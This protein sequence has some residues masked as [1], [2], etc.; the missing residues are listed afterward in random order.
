MAKTKSRLPE[1]RTM[2]LYKNG[3][4]TK[5]QSRNRTIIIIVA[6]VFFLVAVLGRYGLLAYKAMKLKN[7]EAQLASY[8][9]QLTNYKEVKT[10][11][12]R[13]AKTFM[14]AEEKALED[15]TT[16]IICANNC[17]HDYGKI[18]TLSITG[19]AATATVLINNMH[20]VPSIVGKFESFNDIAFVD[21]GTISR[22]TSEGEEGGKS[23]NITLTINYGIGQ[24]ADTSQEVQ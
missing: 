19:N 20:D 1:K 2:N 17:I 6:I 15:R 12:D 9:S 10:E 23:S 7:A 21:V 11:Y 4:K 3:D 13:Y 14:S 16:L 24:Q 5:K 22:A 18:Q 8:E